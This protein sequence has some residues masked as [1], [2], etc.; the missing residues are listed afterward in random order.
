MSFTR[1]QTVTMDGVELV[2][3][4]L[5]CVQADEFLSTQ[6]EIFSS[7]NGDEKSAVEKSKKLE[8]LWYKFICD[9]MNNANPDSKMTTERLRSEFDKVFL[10]ALKTKIMEMSGLGM[11]GEAPTA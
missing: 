2:V 10:D 7:Q 3:S 5:T 8:S 9:G 1:K 4:P 11:K 6:T